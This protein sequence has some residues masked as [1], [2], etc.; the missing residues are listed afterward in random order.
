MESDE[1]KHRDEAIASGAHE[2]PSIIKKTMALMSK[3][4][5]K[6]VKYI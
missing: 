3:V 2:L 4:M 6:T 5:V 1:A